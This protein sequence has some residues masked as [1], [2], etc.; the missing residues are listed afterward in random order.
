MTSPRRRR[1]GWL[2]ET[3]GLTKRFGGL[4]AVDGLPLT[5]RAARSA[6]SSGPTA[7]A[8]PPRS[9]CSPASTGPTP[10]RSI[11]AASAS[12]TCARIEIAA[13]GVART[14]QIPKLLGNMTVLENVLVPALAERDRGRAGPWPRS[15]TRARRLL[16]F[17]TL[18]RLRHALAKELSGG[19]EHAAPDRARAHG[20]PDPPLPD[21]RALRRR[22]PDDQGHDHGDDPP[23]EPGGGRD[24]P[25]RVPRDGD[26]APAVPARV[27]DARGAG[28]SPRARSRRWPTTPLVLEAYLGG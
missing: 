22:A 2:L 4:V 28:S 25:H 3:R 5:V 21:G 18:D 16:D 24:V 17:V 27:G 10:A 14:F 26:P 8:R 13:R 7:R 23:H 20:A 9:I 1:P 19:P 11:C 12:T 15:S 6:A